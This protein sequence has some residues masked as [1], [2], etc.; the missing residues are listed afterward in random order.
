MHKIYKSL[1]RLDDFHPVIYINPEKDIL[2][3]PE[4]AS[5]S[6]KFHSIW[7]DIEPS[8]L[9][10]IQRVALDLSFWEENVSGDVA[11][12]ALNIFESLQRATIVVACGPRRRGA[13][14]FE[15]PYGATFATHGSPHATLHRVRVNGAREKV[16]RE[17]L[18]DDDKALDQSLGL[19]YGAD[20]AFR[21]QGIMA[22]MSSGLVRQCC[23]SSVWRPPKIEIKVLIRQ[24]RVSS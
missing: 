19:D 16:L 18:A 15:A 24:G 4:D 7:Q 23:T 12:R 11:L 8:V 3:I 9:V 1:L 20:R 21:L 5:R 2:Y 17:D 22:V 14:S 13:I 10:K 6:D